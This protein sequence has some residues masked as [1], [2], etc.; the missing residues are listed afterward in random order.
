MAR[1]AWNFGTAPRDVS[2]FGFVVAENIRECTCD[3]GY[4]EF[5]HEWGCGYDPI[6]D[7]GENFDAA[8]MWDFSFVGSLAEVTTHG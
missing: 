2:T 5:G 7:L 4:S 3:F 6:G 8:I 1:T